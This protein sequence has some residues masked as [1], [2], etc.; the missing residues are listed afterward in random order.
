LI[1]QQRMELAMEFLADSDEPFAEMKTLVARSEILC[2]RARARVFLTS[3][4]NVETRKAA[5]ETHV[6]VCAADDTYIAAMKEFET[7]RAKRGRAEILIDVWR[8]LNASMRK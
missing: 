3:D 4:G 1:D 2:K 5:A 6:E 7:L 8:S